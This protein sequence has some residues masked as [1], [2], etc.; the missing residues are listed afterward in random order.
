MFYQLRL[1]ST[2]RSN[3]ESI[4]RLTSLHADPCGRLERRDLHIR[5]N[6]TLLRAQIE[7]A[8]TLAASL[9]VNR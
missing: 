6:L 9:Q 5:G 3:A 2:V 8:R 4:R 7:R 1:V